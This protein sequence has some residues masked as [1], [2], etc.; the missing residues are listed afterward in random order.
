MDKSKFN[1]IH[2]K[3][4][5]KLAKFL[6][7]LPGKGEFD[8]STWRT[9]NCK[10]VGC[11]V[12]WCPEAFKDNGKKKSFFLEY[13]NQFEDDNG[14]MVKS[15]DPRVKNIRSWF[16]LEEAEFERLFMSHSGSGMKFAGPHS[17]S[18]QVSSRIKQF[19]AFKLKGRAK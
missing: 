14:N 16:G 6:K 7:D 4:L 12:G 8:F 19:V 15:Y 1:K 13:D 18:L 9:D 11:A 10:T 2:A 3:R 5:L 17:T